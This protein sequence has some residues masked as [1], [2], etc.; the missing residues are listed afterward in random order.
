[1]DDLRYNDGIGQA[2]IKAGSVS[3][4]FLIAATVLCFGCTLISIGFVD[5][6][7]SM[8]T[9]NGKLFLPLVICVP[10]RGVAKNPLFD[11]KHRGNHQ[12]CISTTPNAGGVHSHGAPNMLS[13]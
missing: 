1:M 12:H 11:N 8:L 4:V 13:V 10:G 3:Q 6:N 2:K 7:I 9:R 5:R